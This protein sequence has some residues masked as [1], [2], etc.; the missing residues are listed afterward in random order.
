MKIK[1]PRLTRKAVDDENMLVA[2]VESLNIRQVAN[3]INIDAK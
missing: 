3:P 2:I 1:I